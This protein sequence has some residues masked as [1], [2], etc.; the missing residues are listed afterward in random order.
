MGCCHP[1]KKPEE[2]E[3]LML[4]SKIEKENKLIYTIP[5]YQDNYLMIT[6]LS[7]NSFKK[8]QKKQ[9]LRI[10]FVGEIMKN[11][12]K[13]NNEEK[14]EKLT[15]KLLFYILILTLTLDNY[16]NERKEKI[17]NTKNII[18]D[19]NNTNDLQQFL[20][21]LTVQIL[22]K[23]F[24]DFQNL[25]L[26]VYYLAHLL[27]ILFSEIKEL[28]QYFNIEKYIN[29]IQKISERKKI[30]KD[31]EMYPFIKI[32]LLCLGNCFITN[33]HEITLKEQSINILINYYVEAYLFK[34][35]FLSNNYGTFSKYLYYF[36]SNSNSSYNNN[37]KSFNN[38][39]SSKIGI[40]EYIKNNNNF[41][42]TTNIKNIDLSF[43]GMPT[44]QGNALKNSFIS[45]NNE[46]ISFNNN[47]FIEIAKTPEFRDIQLITGSMYSF[48][49]ISIQDILSGKKMFQK[50]GGIV[51][52]KLCET[53]NEN[54]KNIIKI[55]YLFLFN[56]CRLEI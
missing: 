34:I 11:I 45:N 22:N 55:I 15:K 40:N 9:Q 49:K 27:N 38:F 44:I 50:I 19:T 23:P 7:A 4:F 54:S 12:Y 42:S 28:N 33:F 5:N 48:L 56:K 32:N 21:A 51:E 18:N 14:E 35:T 46:D 10:G 8:L 36:N 20:L 3:I 30:F 41:L 17:E 16:L 39:C 52:E 24:Q 53:N 6:N 37:N 26:I 25:K 1:E 47:E 13:L 29:L 31:E 43:I 2:N